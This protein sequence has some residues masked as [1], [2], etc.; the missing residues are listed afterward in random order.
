[1]GVSVTLCVTLEGSVWWKLYVI[2]VTMQE[3]G[4]VC[5]GFLR[6][7]WCLPTYGR[8]FSITGN[9]VSFSTDQW[10]NNNAKWKA[11]ANLSCQLGQDDCSSL[12]NSE[13]L[14]YLLL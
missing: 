9:A 3:A 5:M 12:M 13:V 7:Y 10:Q 11:F 6:V 14:P 1:M 4:S 2:H 8:G